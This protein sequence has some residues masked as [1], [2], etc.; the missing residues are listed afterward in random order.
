MTDA[1]HGPA[2]YW[3]HVTSFYQELIDRYGWKQGA[4]LELVERLALSSWADSIYPSTSHEALGLSL[5]EFYEERRN[6]PM[7]Y[8][9]Y[10]GD[11]DTFEIIYQE[12]QG[13]TVSSELCQRIDDLTWERILAWLRRSSA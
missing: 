3:R 2:E 6:A 7:V 9:Q 12:G 4:M 10:S 11:T 5:H 8:L 13:H 1:R